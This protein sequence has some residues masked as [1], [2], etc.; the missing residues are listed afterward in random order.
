[1]TPV[2][3]LVVDDSAYL[4]KVLTQMLTQG[5]GVRVV[6]TAG[7]GDEALERLDELKPDV[8]TLDLTMP[9]R[10]GLDFL[11]AI[12][13]GER[14]PVIVVSS[15]SEDGQD[16]M[17][18]MEAGAFDF[19]QKPTALANERVFSMARELVEKVRAAAGLSG[20][21]RQVLYAVP[22]VVVPAR[23]SRVPRVETHDVVVI[24]VSTGGPLALKVV[25]SGLPADLP[26]PVLAVLHMP[27]G[28]TAAY[29]AR[30]DESCPLQVVE[31]A[32]GLEL[33]PGRVV[34]ARGGSH[35][36][37][38]GRQR[39]AVTSER[40]G[41]LHCP[42]VDVLFESAANVFGGRVLA[43]VMTGMGNDGTAGARAIKARGGTVLAQSEDTCVV[44]GMPRSVVEAG[45]ADEV[46]PLSDLAAA[47]MR[48]L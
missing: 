21:Q 40:G 23:P 39:V 37:V 10:S 34:L 32:D 47:V 27:E 11:Q 17:A 43:I 44:Y 13:H 16:V 33:Q 24:G 15:L 19:V 6:G 18:A 26:V 31:A 20:W 42:A 38:P 3:V 1:M 45:L 4:R 48:H 41:L 36:S 22:P 35:L 14:V 12:G 5:E 2:R 25:L 8:V 7:D 30:L 9:R 46:V 29:A 28:Y